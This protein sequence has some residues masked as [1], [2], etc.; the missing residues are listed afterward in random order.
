MLERGD[1]VA[2]PK[3]PKKKKAIIHMQRRHTYIHNN[4]THTYIHTYIHQYARASMTPGDPP[5][6]C[7]PLDMLHADYVF[8]HITMN[9]MCMRT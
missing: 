9:I 6:S 7:V 3:P 2:L 1:F 5:V 8:P 4:H